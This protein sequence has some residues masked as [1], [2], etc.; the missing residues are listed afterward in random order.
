LK[1]LNVGDPTL[2]VAFSF[3]PFRPS[4]SLFLAVVSRPSSNDGDGTRPCN[5]FLASSTFS[6]ALFGR[7][8]FR[9]ARASRALCSFAR[10]AFSAFLFSA[11]FAVAA[12]MD[13]DRLLFGFAGPVALEILELDDEAIEPVDEGTRSIVFS[14]LRTSPPFVGAC[15]GDEM[16]SVRGII[17]ESD[18]FRTGGGKLIASDLGCSGPFVALSMGLVSAVSSTTLR[19]S[20]PVLSML[21]PLSRFNRS[22]SFRNSRL[23]SGGVGILG[24]SV[25]G[26]LAVLSIT[27]LSRESFLGG[28]TW[29]G[30]GLA[31]RLL[32]DVEAMELLESADLTIPRGWGAARREDAL[33]E[34]ELPSSKGEIG[35]EIGSCRS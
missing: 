28:G 18:L 31:L 5:D 11:H 34:I 6:T 10:A 33:L 7:G 16:R 20:V 2:S 35:R 12:T 8:S 27:I 1:T 3:I 17:L 32:E 24:G 14:T 26:G 13:G 4:T 29:I 23:G 21:S 30:A 22:H 25:I 15:L 19:I 9:A